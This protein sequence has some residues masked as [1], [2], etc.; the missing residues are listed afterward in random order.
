M[1]RNT[2]TAAAARRRSR[3]QAQFTAMAATASLA[4]DLQMLRALNAAQDDA[5]LVAA[6]V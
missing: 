3:N 6:T 5:T 2:T 4:A 1:R